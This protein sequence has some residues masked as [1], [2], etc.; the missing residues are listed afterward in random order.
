MVALGPCWSHL[1]S[2]IFRLVP[3]INLC[4]S[5]IEHILLYWNVLKKLG[6]F[7]HNM[8]NSVI[9]IINNLV[10]NSKHC[11]QSRKKIWNGYNWIWTTTNPFVLCRLV[12]SKLILQQHHLNIL[13]MPNQHSTDHKIGTKIIQNFSFQS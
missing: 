10:S 7:F 12:Q 5:F 2:A 1:L 8:F 3:N 13:L 9:I 6:F 4:A 11:M